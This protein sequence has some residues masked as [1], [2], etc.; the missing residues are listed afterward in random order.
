MTA[1]LYLE[2]NLTKKIQLQNFS[3]IT[4]EGGKINC[5]KWLYQSVIEM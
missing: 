3:K 2:V 1:K 4:S 5:K